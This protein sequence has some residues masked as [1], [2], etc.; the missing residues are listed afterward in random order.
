MLLAPWTQDTTSL[1]NQISEWSHEE[2][3]RVEPEIEHVD[4]PKSSE[5]MEKHSMRITTPEGRIHLEPA[6]RKADGR[7]V[8]DMY[9][10]PTLVRVRLLQVP[11]SDAWQVVTSE[12]MPFYWDW[13]KANFTRLVHD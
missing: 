2:G 8:V 11:G 1:F 10:Y 9:A 7:V 4:L 13:N 6:G 5:L 12:G 3:W